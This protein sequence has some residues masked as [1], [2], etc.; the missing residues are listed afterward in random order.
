MDDKIKVI[1]SDLGNVIIPFDY[2][3]LLNKLD[4]Y[5]TGLGEKFGKLYMENYHVHR[6]FEK[7]K[8]SDKDF[9]KI[10]MN[11]TEHLIPENE[12]IIL[13][14][15]IFTVNND[16]VDLLT[17][18]KKH[19]KL[20]LLSNTNS[21]HKKY[22]WDKYA[23]V[24]IFDKLILSHEV[25]SAKPEIEIYKAVENFTQL[26]SQSHLFID[27]IKEYV[28]AAKNLNWDAIQFKNFTQLKSELKKRNILM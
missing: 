4:S 24:S 13:F 14:S 26:P 27:D 1:V 17:N 9:L 3:P 18:L 21:I 19:Y 12:F 7:G 25:G 10:M 28:D 16:V 2:K 22:G 15:D 5:K 11:W 8:L 20:V 6:S 23:F